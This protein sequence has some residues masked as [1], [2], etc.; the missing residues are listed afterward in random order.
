[1][2]QGGVLRK[3]IPVPKDDTHKSCVPHLDPLRDQKSSRNIYIYIFL[4]YEVYIATSV[5]T[6]MQISDETGECD[7]LHASCGM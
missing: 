1:M 7:V 6:D 2:F 4:S 5:I 3:G